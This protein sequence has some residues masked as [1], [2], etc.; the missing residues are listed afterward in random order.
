MI[1]IDKLVNK[2]ILG[3]CL[4]VMRSIPDKSIDCIICDLPYGTTQ[5]SWDSVIPF[6]PLWFQFKRIAKINS[7]IVLN[8][9]QPFTSALIMSNIKNYKYSWIWHKNKATGHLD[10][11]RKPLKAHEDICIFYEK[12][13]TYNPQ[14]TEGKPYTNKHKPG[15]NGDCYG[16]VKESSFQ[17]KGTRFP[18]TIIKFPVVMRPQHP[19]EKPVSLC[20]YLIKTYTNKGD[21][22]LDNCAGSG[23][24]LVAAQNLGRNFIG[25]EKENKYYEII[26]ERLKQAKAA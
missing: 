7:A 23:S 14:L 19:T 13:P 3:D 24:T 5:N 1:S 11:R 17:N 6:E 4:K 2:V 9:A 15:D 20:E 26:K 10:A 21:I 22:I 12:F 25:I 18:Q 8:A 16:A